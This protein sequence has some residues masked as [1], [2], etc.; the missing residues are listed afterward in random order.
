MSRILLHAILLLV[1]SVPAF[2]Q[3]VSFYHEASCPS[4]DRRSMQ[5]MKRTVAIA[6]GMLPAPDCHPDARVRYLGIS[7]ASW[8]ALSD[9]R[10][11]VGGYTR[12]DGTQVGPYDRAAP[13][14]PTDERIHV[15]GYRR[16]DGTEVAPYER[17]P[18]KR[19]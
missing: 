9:A 13:S 7:G 19:D 6:M 18:A 12:A 8:S 2:A 4:V 3:T 5:R 1:L 16:A 14:A 15:S 17:S 10:I 11:H